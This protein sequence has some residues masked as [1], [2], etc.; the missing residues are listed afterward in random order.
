[1]FILCFVVFCFFD[2]NEERKN[3]RDREENT[4]SR[5]FVVVHE[6]VALQIEEIRFPRRANFVGEESGGLQSNGFLQLV[7]ELQHF[8]IIRGG[9]PGEG[10][11]LVF[12]EYPTLPSDA[13]SV[14]I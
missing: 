4:Y 1:M 9:Y 8:L 13:A 11:I 14:L 6:F 5:Y 7:D 10:L 3:K 12:R 2:K